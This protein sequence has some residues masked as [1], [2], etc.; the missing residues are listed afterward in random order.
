MLLHRR[1]PGRLVW[2]AGHRYAFPAVLANVQVV[3]VDQPA[4]RTHS[5]RFDFREDATGPNGVAL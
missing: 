5:I 4:A 3:P 2:I 1:N